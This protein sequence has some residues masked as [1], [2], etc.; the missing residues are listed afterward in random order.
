MEREQENFRMLCGRTACKGRI[1]KARPL[2]NFTP[3]AGQMEGEKQE[4]GGFN[5]FARAKRPGER[6]CAPGCPPAAIKIFCM[7]RNVRGI[8]GRALYRW[9]R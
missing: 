5:G 9:M 1:N 7:E 2:I 3:R 6:A 4:K 8:K